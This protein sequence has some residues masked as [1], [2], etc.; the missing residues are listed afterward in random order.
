MEDT[1]NFKPSN[2]KPLTIFI[3]FTFVYM[4]LSNF[5]TIHIDIVIIV[6]ILAEVLT[7]IGINYYKITLMGHSMRCYDMWGKFY[8]ID[9]ESIEEIKPANFLG[10]HYLRLI[11]KSVD[12]TIWLPLFLSNIKAFSKEI[13]E[14]TKP[15][16]PLREYFVSHSI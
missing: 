11:T 4:L 5:W 3:L 12:H 6:A 14:R 16:N 9:L 15:D 13:K 8:L 7:Q 1:K 10:L 2:I